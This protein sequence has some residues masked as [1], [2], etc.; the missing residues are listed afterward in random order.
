M[1][2][3]AS[4]L[5]TLACGGNSDETLPTR[6]DG[7]QPDAA[8]E[9]DARVVESCPEQL[10]P[11][12]H[13]GDIDQDQTWSAEGSPHLVTGT[14][15][16]RSGAT[17]TVEPCALVQVAAGA[18]IHIAFPG[19]PNSGA[20]VAE[21]TAQRPIVFEGASA[22]RWD[23]IYVVHP[24][25]LRLAH[26][27]L[28]NGGG[29]NSSMG[30]TIFI[31]GD[32]S[33]PSD[34]LLRVADVIIEDSRGPGLVLEGVAKFQAGSRALTVRD[35][36]EQEH[37]YP[38][39]LNEHAL[40][41]LPDGSY[42]GNLN[43]RILI[44]SDAVG[45]LREDGTI[46]DRGVP[47]LTS[48]YTG[49]N[50]DFRVEALE[51]EPPVVLTIEPGVRLEFQ[52]GAALEIGHF[53]GEGPALATIVAVGTPEK[54]ILF[55]SAQAAPAAGDWRGLWFGTT[56]SADNRLEHVQIEYTGADC[57]CIFLTCDSDLPSY[58]G[59]LVFSQPP[60]SM[61]LK[62]SRIVHGSAN[63]VVQGYQGPSFDWTAGNTLDDLAG[64]KQTRPWDVLEPICPDPRPLCVR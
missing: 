60:S 16:I 10:G 52:R 12:M 6:R 22:A 43:D 41:S 44:E 40:D 11:T 37:P 49:Q 17:V 1:L 9:I 2:A 35:S 57:G 18:G 34:G 54:P 14:V 51:N 53:T 61:F 24:G 4:C 15:R 42:T 62:S 36:G 8:A 48:L 28:R 19:T 27:T 38:V 23:R 45:G 5:C 32:G 25:T 20:L 55:S 7:G 59:A 13:S 26:T 39:V 58:S 64:C 46:H 63:G 31:S 3:T 29:S 50:G 30:E 21:G 33:L 56:P 47:Y